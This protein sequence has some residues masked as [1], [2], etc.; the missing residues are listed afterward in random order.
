MKKSTRVLIIGGFL[1]FLVS[2]IYI[3]FFFGSNFNPALGDTLFTSQP[4]PQGG[5]SNYST[6]DGKQVSFPHF[7][8]DVR[9]YGWMVLITFSL[10]VTIL[11][12][13]IPLFFYYIGQ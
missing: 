11:L 7:S 1:F 13:A 12:F 3:Y 10:F 9:I 4:I 8:P 5:T 2:V 6:P